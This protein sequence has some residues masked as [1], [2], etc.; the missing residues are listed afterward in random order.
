MMNSDV[1][2]RAATDFSQI[3]S[4]NYKNLTKSEKQIADYVR[5]NQEESAFLSAGELAERLS[6]SEAT[7]VRFARSLGFDSY[8]AMREVL[9][10]NF[11]RRVTHSAR[12]RSR[13]DDLRETGDIFERLVA[14]EI[15]YMTQSLES[16]NREAL[17]QA[18]DLMKNRKRIFIF[19]LG[20]SISLVELMK[21]R[22]ERFGRQVIP[23]TTAGREFLEPLM[24]MTKD[25]LLFVIC[26]FDVTPA[27]QLVLDY[28]RDVY[29]P[30]VMLTDTLGSIIGDKA[31][32]VLSA[33]RGPVAGF[34]SFVV[35]MTIINSI[36][37][38]MAG[39]ES[40]VMENLDKLDQLRERLKKYSGSPT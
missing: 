13:L 20:P 19:G 8:P 3:I 22:L 26:F 25:D 7:L 34:H 18:V 11:R 32:V 15:D 31:E 6:L 28:A 9:Q 17:H 39:E 21:I 12:L 4:E 30:V 40:G 27:L 24:S 38:A 16:V 23:L 1:P 29:C 37:L 10:E 33:K 36:L 5:K 14:S 35:P 2:T